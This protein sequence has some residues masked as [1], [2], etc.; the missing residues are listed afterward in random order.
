MAFA[1]GKVTV[2][3]SVKIGGKDVTADL[4]PRVVAHLEAQ[5]RPAPS[6]RGFDV[7]LT[8]APITGAEAAKLFGVPENMIGETAPEPERELTFGVEPLIGWRA[9]KVKTYR[10]LDGTVEPRLAPISDTLLWHPRERAVGICTASGDYHQAMVDAFLFGNGYV[11]TDTHEAP[12]PDCRC[13]LW[14][15][16]DRGIAQAKVSRGGVF[17]RVAM[18]GRVLEF[19]KG[20]RAQYAYPVE[21]YGDTRNEEVVR[22]L[23]ELYGVP[24]RIVPARPEVGELFAQVGISAKQAAIV[25]VNN[26]DT[27]QLAVHAAG[28]SD[29]LDVFPTAAGARVHVDALEQ[30]LVDTA[31]KHRRDRRFRIRFQTCGGTYEAIA[32]ATD[33]ELLRHVRG[34]RPDI[35]HLRNSFSEPL[36][37][38]LRT[39]GIQIYDEFPPASRDAHH[40]NGTQ[41]QPA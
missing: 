12:H 9:W 34:R 7:A 41:P 21:I 25:P 37:G 6:Y 35:V 19:K 5:H 24:V 18:W 28:G 14:A 38:F 22:Q 11:R 15:V 29:V 1:T 13:G 20:Y 40:M 17:G 16:R 2:E 27:E 30:Q 32:A 26:A 8:T 31:I 33:D 3:L 4:H 39:H 23:G 36:R 10:R